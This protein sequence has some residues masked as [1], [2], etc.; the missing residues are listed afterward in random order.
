[1]SSIM[2]FE[3]V[4]IIQ[5][6]LFNMTSMTN[7]GFGMVIQTTTST[8]SIKQIQPFYL[9]PTRKLAR[10]PKQQEP[11]SSLRTPSPSPPQKKR[12]LK[13]EKQ[14][15]VW[16]IMI[17]DYYDLIYLS[18]AIFQMDPTG[19]GILRLHRTSAVYF[20]ICNYCKHM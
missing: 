17:S 10:I 19:I 20:Y 16:N 3:L 13:L 5:L 9:A 14:T 8:T 1:M 6:P 11:Y 2:V 7:L 18:L 12:N 4:H 15:D